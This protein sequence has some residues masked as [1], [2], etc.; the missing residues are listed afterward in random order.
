MRSRSSFTHLAALLCLLLLIAALPSSAQQQQQ[1]QQQLERGT[2]EEALAEIRA[3]VSNFTAWAAQ[4]QAAAATAAS[5]NDTDA[6]G[7]DVVTAQ[8][9]G[10]STTSSSES[11]EVSGNDTPQQGGGEVLDDGAA[12]AG[13]A[14]AFA[15]YMEAIRL[16]PLA[17]ELAPDAASR[18]VSQAPAEW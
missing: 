1:Q 17:A 5:G 4:V 8:G 13:I 7:R 2:L 9:D 12:G 14:E 10:S 6:S 11:G 16:S 18:G 3:V 15:T